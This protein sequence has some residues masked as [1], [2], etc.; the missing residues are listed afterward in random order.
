MVAD[1]IPRTM[2]AAAAAAAAA[3][4]LGKVSRTSGEVGLRGDTG[5]Q[6]R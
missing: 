2:A 3:A 4:S 5:R 1:A 6:E